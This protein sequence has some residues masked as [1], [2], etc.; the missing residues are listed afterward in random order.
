MPGSCHQRTRLTRAYNLARHRGAAAG[1]AMFDGNTSVATARAFLYGYNEGDPAIMDLAP[2][3]C[4]GEW[5]G[6]SIPELFDLPVGADWPSDEEI[7]AY[8]DHFIE[9][10]WG[11]A[12]AYA[13]SIVEGA[14]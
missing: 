11:A 1:D 12:V 7:I 3:P 2:N 8:E 6:E 4:S 14:E 9:C 13:T 10:W 5:A